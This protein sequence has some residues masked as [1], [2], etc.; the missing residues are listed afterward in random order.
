MFNK[1][2]PFRDLM[3]K[4]QHPF[5]HFTESPSAQ[6]HGYQP[7][8]H[9]HFLLWSSPFYQFSWSEPHG[10]RG[11]GEK[12]RQDLQVGLPPAQQ[13]A[14]RVLTGLHVSLM[15][16]RMAWENVLS[17][18]FV[19]PPQVQGTSLAHYTKTEGCEDESIGGAH[20]D[21]A[22]Q[23][24]SVTLQT[25]GLQKIRALRFPFFSRHAAYSL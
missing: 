2:I 16:S 5:S 15:N 17:R 7:Q 4:T 24:H 11:P 3:L 18:L 20:P 22:D 23:R 8:N 13:I 14:V 21:N 10:L 19:L 1:Y 6:D 9:R 12:S 25:V